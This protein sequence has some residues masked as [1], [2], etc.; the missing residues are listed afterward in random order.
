MSYSD[1]DLTVPQ[2]NGP[3]RWRQPFSDNEVLVF[4]QDWQVLHDYYEPS[5]LDIQDDDYPD[6]F[7][8]LE[9]PATSVGGP[10]L[11]MTRSYA[12]VPSVRD[13]WESF[14][15]TFPGINANTVSPSRPYYTYGREPMTLTVPSRVRYDYWHVGFSITPV[16]QTKIKNPYQIPVV[17]AQRYWGI[18]GRG[19][20]ADENKLGE[21]STPTSEQYLQL[22]YSTSV[23]VPVW[24]SAQ[25]V[26]LVYQGAEIV[27]EDSTINRWM[28][29]IWERKTRY[30]RAQ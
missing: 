3:R 25:T 20:P 28:G 6:F 17:E 18:G 1:G 23:P 10:V 13:E 26:H 15:Y 30:V 21:L 4:D 14:S 12:K 27:A 9:S 8:V 7:L 16:T 11:Q 22:V 29:N 24:P 5:V 2:P 19:W